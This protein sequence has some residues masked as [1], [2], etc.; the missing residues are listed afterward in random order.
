VE[1]D[2][3]EKIESIFHAALEK[4][5]SARE[6]FVRQ[7]CDGDTFL[8][9]EIL[10][11]LN[12]S[13]GTE[14]FLNAPALHVAARALA[15]SEAAV[16]PARRALPLPEFIGHYRVIRLLGEGGMGLV[17][18]S[19]QTAPVRRQVAL[20]LIRSGLYDDSALKRFQSE[21]QSLAV[22]NHPAI[23]KVFEAGTTPEGQPYFVME[24][25]DGSSINKYCDAKKLSIRDRLALFIKVCEGVQH[26]HQKAIVHRD[27]KP[28]N[29]LVTEIDGQ[30]VPRIIDFGIAK[31]ISPRTA[32]EQS[33]TL[34]SHGGTL[35]G[36]PGYMSPEQAAGVPN[37]DGRTDVY[38]LG[39]I[40]YALLTGK[41][42][43]DTTRWSKQPF[44]EVVR[45]IREDDPPSPSIKLHQDKDTSA[46]VAQ[47]RS[48]L[49]DE[50]TRT[51]RGDL[52]WITLKAI[53]RDSSRRY[54]TPS[55]LAADLQR[56]LNHEPVFARPASIA[57]RLSKYVRRHRIALT[58]AGGSLIVFVTVAAA[59]FLTWWIYSRTHREPKLTEKDTIVL[60]DF[61]NKT[62][63]AIF[64]DALKQA[65][66]V[67][68]GQSPFLNIVSDRRVS[69]T[70]RMMGRP[71]NERITMDIGQE[72]CVRTGSKA[73]LGGTISR[74]GDHY[75]LNLNAFACNA[76]D[77]L[78]QEQ[79][80]AKSRED[81]LK[82]LSRISTSLRGKLGESLPSVQKFNVPMEATTSSLEA[83]RNFS[84]GMK[85]W[86]QGGDAPSIP[87]FK[88]AIQLDP[89]FP[90]AYAML[91]TIYG[92]LLQ[93]SV[94][95]EY[96]TKA[97]QLRDRVT[98]REKMRITEFYFRA[99]G[100]LDKEVETCELWIAEYPRD[101]GPHGTLGQLYHDIGQYDKALAEYQTLMRL[102]PNAVL[103]YS[104]LGVGYLFLNRLDEA[105]AVFD[106][107][108]GRGLD[109]GNLHQQIYALA[110]L[111]GDAAQMEQQVAWGAGKPGIE[112]ILLS[113]QSD[114]EA[115]FGRMT[116]ARDYS[117]R[118]VDSAVRGDSKEKA[119]LWQVNAALREAELGNGG[120][121][122]REVAK[123][124]ALSPG[125]DVKVI[126]A[127]AL[128]RA[129]DASRAE[130]LCKEMEKTYPTNTLMKFYWLPSLKAAIEISNNKP[131]RA[132]LSL[133]PTGT[134]ELGLADGY[135]N[136]LYPAYLRGQAYLLMHNG[137]A[138]TTEFQK[139]LDHQ[140]I[141]QNFVTGS[142]AH[143]QMGRAY[144]LS[145][146]TARAKPA[147]QT[148]LN[149]WKDA[150]PDVPILTQAKAEFAKLQ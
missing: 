48:T 140:G 123:A 136:Y 89:D 54:A 47:Q 125:R 81:V 58:S 5:Q 80:E 148:F 12:A 18:L 118:A 68:L 52:D 33:L 134:Y 21:Q 51:L 13:G 74:L 95:L 106:Q 103:S 22:M 112:D 7:A 98:E 110:F 141:V 91:S 4:E 56:Y 102:A 119:A 42:P 63:D 96:A 62:G 131:S 116:E 15:S 45:Q 79:G 53:E 124:L 46:V 37:L 3:W 44:D 10:S 75:L 107:A 27:L 143:L 41:L 130:A 57:Y 121:A 24:Y 114:T 144:A 61:D 127:L 86:Y 82:T 85:V 40:L 108:L 6:Q 23:A 111:R 60:T 64:D 145:G 87:F 14:E 38:S 31:A 77:N 129:G 39:V 59:A 26:A 150:D 120:A 55:E 20:K 66:A 17:L 105:K 84:M 35:V 149:L 67:D 126:A 36:T 139:L 138:A 30:P 117:R 99:R 92:N 146:D 100:E 88:Q 70:L 8:C 65:L 32:L 135:I 115:Y 113:M 1:P 93:P 101:P 122:R 11:L 50:L 29:V 97:Y 147:Y 90:M 25:V 34:S 83:L 16:G 132:L 104:G 43:F 72:L 142:L 78:A 73:L 2:N 137:A 109:S 71:A 133:E 49:P 94:Q 28:S 19:E 128:A 9:Q 76:G 69:A